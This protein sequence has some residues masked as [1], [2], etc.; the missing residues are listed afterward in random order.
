MIGVPVPRVNISD[1]GIAGEL[2]AGGQGKVRAVRDLLINGRWPAAVKIYS[3]VAV[4]NANTAVLERIAGFPHQLSPD[5]SRWLYENTAWPSVIVEDHGAVC[6]FLMREVPAPYYFGFQTQTLGTRRHLA[7]MAFLLNPDRYISSSGLSVSDRDRLGLLASV[8]SALSRLH[9]LGVTVGDLSP[10]NLLFSLGPPSCF[11]IDC[12]AMRVRGESVLAQVETPDWEVPTRE[13]R[14]TPASDAYKF[15]LLAIRLFARDQSSYDRH[16]LALLSPELNKLAEESLQS[17]PSRRPPLTEWLPA[18]QAARITASAT[19]GPGTGSP[20]GTYMPRPPMTPRRTPAAKPRPQQPS[21]RRNR[22]L[23][24]IVGGTAAV[25][26]A[27]AIATVIGLHATAAPSAAPQGSTSGPSTGGGG[28]STSQQ[29]TQVNDL[30][31]SSAASRQSLAS[32]VQEVDNCS[33]LSSAISAISAVAHQRSDEYS[34]ASGLSTT[35]LPN[36]AALKSDLL[37]AL[38]YSVD[39][40]KDFLTWAQEQ[41]NDGCQGTAS[42]TPAYSAGITASAHAVTAKN[43]FLG[44]WNPVASSQGLPTRSQ[45]GI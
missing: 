24:G 44:L 32:A 43:D 14:A 39:A 45:Q 30:L 3:S 1:L 34:Q 40:D 12:D 6:G 11:I 26:A 2:G 18:L 16:P 25:I 36:G 35:A 9:S 41:L 33:D 15:G 10:K 13:E 7:D 4:S 28:S 37:S 20:A 29:A 17:H 23:G 27:A 22:R 8:A 19:A 38:G 42:D 5:D 31:D 21:A